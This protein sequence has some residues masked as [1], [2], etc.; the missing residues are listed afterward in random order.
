[1]VGSGIIFK[2]MCEKIEI[3]PFGYW[4]GKIIS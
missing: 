3:D 4:L 2:Q 1:M